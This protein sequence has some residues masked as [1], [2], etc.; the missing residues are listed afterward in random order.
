MLGRYNEKG[1]SCGLFANNVSN[2]MQKL[3]H[4]IDKFG[5]GFRSH[6]QGIC[7]GAMLCYAASE[8]KLERKLPLEISF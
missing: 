6:Q 3:S 2:V 1:D 7:P 4:F 5:T 8:V